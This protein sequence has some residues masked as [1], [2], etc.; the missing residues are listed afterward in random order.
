MFYMPQMVQTLRHEGNPETPDDEKPVTSF[1]VER[2][3]ASDAFA[4]RIFWLLRSE[5]TPPGG[6]LSQGMQVHRALSHSTHPA[7]HCAALARSQLHRETSNFAYPQR[8]LSTLRSRGPA[9]N[10]PRT[11]G[12]GRLPTQLGGG[13][14][15]PCHPG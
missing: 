5:G 11:L 2:S 9:G 8:R 7:L 15:G 1:L 4:H 3:A 10:L 12:C 6:M 14:W 13:S